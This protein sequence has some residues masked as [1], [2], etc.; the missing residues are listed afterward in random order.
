MSKL[1]ATKD[2]LMTIDDC[3]AAAIYKAACAQSE[4]PVQEVVAELADAYCESKSLGKR[5]T[6][7]DFDD[8]YGSTITID[9]NGSIT[10]TYADTS[11]HMVSDP[12]PCSVD[13][14]AAM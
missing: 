4:R 9:D 8:D 5:E 14:G 6:E 12:L 7:W 3:L 10:A 2:E 13:Y 11:A 1:I